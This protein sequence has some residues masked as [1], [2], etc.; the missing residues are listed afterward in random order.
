[1]FLLLFF[2]GHLYADSDPFTM[3]GEYARHKKNWRCQLATSFWHLATL[4]IG[5]LTSRCCEVSDFSLSSGKQKYFAFSH[6]LFVHS[7]LALTNK[8]EG[9]SEKETARS[10]GV[11]AR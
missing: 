5:I 1:L 9:H 10:S 8:D 4:N 7:T 11:A 2:A 3:R 6:T